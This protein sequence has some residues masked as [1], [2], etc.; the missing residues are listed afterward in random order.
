MRRIYFMLVGGIAVAVLV[1]AWL[2]SNPLRRSD[3]SVRAWLLIKTPLG[4]RCAD[5][6]AVLE[7]HGWQDDRIQQT[8][9]RPAADPFL[10]GEVGSYQG[11]PWHTSVRAFWE[12]DSSDRL[13]DIRIQRILDSP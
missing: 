1:T 7:H 9:P 5:V 8:L 3:A 11:F 10:G 13:V 12:F 6:R 2:A 4:S